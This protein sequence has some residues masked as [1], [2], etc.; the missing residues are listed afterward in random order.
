M[1]V[2]EA[3]SGAGSDGEITDDTEVV[4]LEANGERTEGTWKSL[5]LLPF[6][7]CVVS[8]EDKEDRDAMIQLYRSLRNKKGID[9]AIMMITKAGAEGLDLKSVRQVH[10]LEPFWN[11]VRVKQVI[12]RGSRNKSHNYLDPA[13]NTVKNFIYTCV[14]S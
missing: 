3:A 4:V 8:G 6:Q 5:N 1:E 2:K 14:L 10:V 9:A 11:E 7:Y 13:E 12:G